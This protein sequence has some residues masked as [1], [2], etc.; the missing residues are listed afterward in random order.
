[1]VTIKDLIVK[2]RGYLP[3]FDE[4]KLE[5][6]YEFAKSAHASQKRYSGE[7]YII[8][9]LH[10]AY[11][12]A[13]FHPDEDT[14]IAALLH[15]VLEDTDR[16][17]EEITKH[18]GKNICS[19]VAG[20]EK[21]GKV[22]A[23]LDLAQAENLQKMFIAMAEDVRVILIKLCDRLHNIRTLE[24][25]PKEKQ[26]RIAKE[27]LDIYAPIASSLGI[28]RLKIALEDAA[29]PYVYREEAAMITQ[30]LKSTEKYREDY[31]AHAKEIIENLLKAEGVECE[32]DG[33]IK[34]LYSI[35]TK[36]QRKKKTSLAEIFDIFAMRI[37]LPDIRK[38]EK[39]YVGHVYAAL[40]II[41]SHFTPLANRFKDYVAI[42]KVNGYQSLHTTVMGLGPKT[43]TSPTEIQIRTKSMH[44]Q[45][46][47]GIASHWFYEAARGEKA[48][49]TK[50]SLLQKQ[51]DWIKK[52]SSLKES[53]SNKDEYFE[54]LKIDVFQDRIFVFTPRGSVK[55]L[56]KGATPVDFA[57]SV[58]SNI[59]DK[60]VMA[61]VNG[62]IVPL[63]YGLRNGEV[64]EII[65]RQNATPSRHWLT[66]VK[67]H[68][69]KSRIRTFFRDV[70]REK[71]LKAGKDL[72]N[73]YLAKIGKP[74]LTTDLGLLK[75]HQ[76]KRLP[77]GERED[78]LVEV[79]KGMLFASAL[80]K[81]LF[82][83]AEI[84][85]GLAN[86]TPRSTPR[87][88]GIKKSLKTKKL[89]HAP[90][91]IFIAGHKDLPYR[92]AKCCS[93]KETDMLIGFVMRG[94][95]VSIHKK[96]CRMVRGKDQKRFQKVTFSTGAVSIA[97]DLED[98]I[99]LMRDVGNLTASLG[100]KVIDFISKRH[101]SF[102]NVEIN[103]LDELEKL[104][105]AL[106]SIPGVKRAFLSRDPEM[107]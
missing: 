87:R 78:L 90:K 38:N 93:A 14:V 29:F 107:A 75:E 45:A 100:I 52:L 91:Q 67:T 99:G 105:R 25:V 95:N 50:P 26:L 85:S 55:D 98:R 27:T 69:A 6:A 4:K 23:S 1:M 96:D 77:Y 71:N 68:H 10:T 84:V 53:I 3:H 64:V 28:Y 17:K 46:E 43:H 9:P 60:A 73:E 36:I 72:V 56:P 41:H 33:R 12:L 44:D 65:T 83:F 106:E 66:F 81:R 54:N 94:G 82:S 31:I 37:M 20:M 13:D 57:Y 15:D 30:E 63:E 89:V 49:Y 80:V 22:R 19:L 40:G 42:P 5:A 92:F 34:S 32:V 16:T 104:L 86:T 70:D 21:V 48:S 59:G 74:L 8:H 79:G 102:L 7:P 11:Y 39:E 2:L 97:L 76:G 88:G 18:F 24:F 47:Y 61:K 51:L 103:S 101:Q 58:H 62:N 35:F